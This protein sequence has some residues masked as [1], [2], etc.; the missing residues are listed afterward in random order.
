LKSYLLTALA[1][2]GLAAAVNA[3]ADVSFVSKFPYDEAWTK[4]VSAIANSNLQ[5]QTMDKASGLIQ[6]AKKQV[7]AGLTTMASLKG[8]ANPPAGKFQVYDEA[9]M[10]VT[11]ILT[12]AGQKTRIS[13][14]AH[15]QTSSHGLL[16]AGNVLDWEPT[17]KFEQMLAQKLQ[18]KPE[19]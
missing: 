3:R 6:T 12:K 8:Y 19:K 16:N 13:I 5:I 10:S 18:A 9:V 14:T 2:L 17:G 7:G 1:L 15:Y 11:F 4:L